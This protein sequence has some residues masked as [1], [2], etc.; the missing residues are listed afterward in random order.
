MTP[1]DVIDL[2]EDWT[3]NCM[4]ENKF[5]SHGRKWELLWFGRNEKIKILKTKK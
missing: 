5:F 2:D 3:V 1:L 4:C